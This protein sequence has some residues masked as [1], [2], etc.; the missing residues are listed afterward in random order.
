MTRTQLFRVSHNV[1]EELHS[2]CSSHGDPTHPEVLKKSQELD[3]LIVQWH[4]LG[5]RDGGLEEWSESFSKI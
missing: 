3:A 4:L 1:R 2:L 5:K